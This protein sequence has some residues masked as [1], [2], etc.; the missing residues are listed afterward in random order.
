MK[1]KF[2]GTDFF[3]EVQGSLL[4]KPAYEK[5]CKTP[6]IRYSNGFFVEHIY[7]G[8]LRFLLAITVVIAH[9]IPAPIIN[10][11]LHPSTSVEIFFIISGFYMQMVLVE[12]YGKKQLGRHFYLNFWTSRY[13]R[14]YPAYA[15]SIF[16]TLIYLVYFQQPSPNL[17]AYDRSLAI[18]NNIESLFSLNNS[19]EN[20]LLKAQVIFSNLFI[21]T[22]DFGLNLAILDGN[23]NIVFDRYNTELYLLDMLLNTPSWSLGVELTFYLLAPFLLTIRNKFLYCILLLTFFIKITSVI[24]GDSSDL[25]YRGFPFVIFDFLLGAVVYRLREHLT[26]LKLNEKLSTLFV[27]LFSIVTLFLVPTINLEH[28]LP[29][30]ILFGILIPTMFNATKNNLYDRFIGELSYPIYIFHFFFYMVIIDYWMSFNYIA[31]LFHTNMSNLINGISLL[32]VI[33]FSIVYVI[34]EKKYV[35]PLRYKLSFVSSSK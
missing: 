11:I 8:L 1:A 5:A 20:I 29:I 32:F 12:K 4:V 34:I 23:A 6:H 9:G 33:L 16:A 35:E 14:L 31:I 19:I 22:S 7:M 26:F 2:E 3:N 17:S 13:L 15:L 27:Y 25:Y 30:I 24:F 28:S 18:E 10:N 21:F